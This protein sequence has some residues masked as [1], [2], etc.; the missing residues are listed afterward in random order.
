ML[1]VASRFWAGGV[2]LASWAVHATS[3]LD[4]RRD[5]DSLRAGQMDAAAA[6]YSHVQIVSGGPVDKLLH[7]LTES[8]DGAS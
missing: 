5:R 6:G 4:N 2:A 7:Q 1:V 8:R 3:S